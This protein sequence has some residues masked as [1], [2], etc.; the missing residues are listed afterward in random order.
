MVMNVI[1]LRSLWSS[2]DQYKLDG[3]GCFRFVKAH[4]AAKEIR[5]FM[6]R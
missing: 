3:N 5:C 1:T 4:C 2:M 6:L